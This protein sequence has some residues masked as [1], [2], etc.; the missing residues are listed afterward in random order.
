MSE[1]LKKYVLP[2]SQEA[3]QKEYNINL[4]KGLDTAIPLDYNRAFTF[5]EWSAQNRAIRDD[6]KKDAYQKYLERWHSNR[7]DKQTSNDIVKNQYKQLIER[8]QFIFK[9]DENFKRLTNINL[10]DPYDVEVLIPL[11]SK[12]LRDIALY[13]TQ[14]R[15]A[16][17]KTNI[18]Y[19]VAGS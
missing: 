11:V 17:K 2:N 14:Q 3:T 4:S 6:L 9:D 8:L 1:V 7:F 10:D 13:Y 18:K 16:A 5:L 15:A 19:N 12:K